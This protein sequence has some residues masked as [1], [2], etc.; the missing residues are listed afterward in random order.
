VRAPFEVGQQLPS[1]RHDSKPPAATDSRVLRLQPPRELLQLLV[2]L[3][4]A[5][6]GLQ[7]RHEFVG[8]RRPH[9]EG[10]RVQAQLHRHPDLGRV[11]QVESCRRH[12]QDRVGSVFQPQRAPDEPPVTPEAP[13][14]E[15]VADEGHRRAARPV[16]SVVEQAAED[17]AHA[18]N[19]QVARRHRRSAQA[20]RLA[21]SDEV[22]EPWRPEPAGRQRACFVAVERAF[23]QRGSEGVETLPQRHAEH[24]PV[25]VRHR[26]RP[27]QQPTRT[28]LARSNDQRSSSGCGSASL[29]AL[30]CACGTPSSRIQ[31]A[32]R[33]H[34]LPGPTPAAAK[35]RRSIRAAQ[36]AAPLVQ[37]PRR[38]A[39]SRLMR[40]STM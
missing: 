3:L 28:V 4:R 16:L 38:T 19:A 13:L 35:G 40:S 24:E 31:E 18:Q 14:P 29:I 15:I 25:H 27:Q 6:P 17:R 2:G 34:R 30:V 8:G 10:Q 37:V 1:Q 39:G 21:G 9:V 32:A 36:P 22:E 5:D 20:L 12:A 23:E 26:Q 11:R 33:A 7:A